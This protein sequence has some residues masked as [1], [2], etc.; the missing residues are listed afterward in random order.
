MASQDQW[1]KLP[2]KRRESLVGRGATDNI[3]AVHC[4]LEG[5][6]A[7]HLVVVFFGK[8]FQS[9]NT[10]ELGNMSKGVTPGVKSL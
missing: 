7:T 2:L 9:M 10:S 4:Q 8:A 3:E 6:S 5:D 1:A